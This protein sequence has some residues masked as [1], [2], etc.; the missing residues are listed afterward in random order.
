MQ[1]LMFPKTHSSRSG[2]TLIELLVVLGII[3]VVATFALPAMN[4][5]LKGSQLTQGAQMISDQINLARQT[6]LSANRSVE[7]RFYQYGDPQTPGEQATSPGTGKYRAIQLFEVQDTGSATALGKVVSMPSSIIL[8]SGAAL[9]TLLGTSLQKT[10]TSSDPQ[11]SLPR[12]G[13]SY[14]CCYMRFLPDGS[15]NLAPSSG[16]PWFLTLHG[17]NDGDGLAKPPT[18]FFTIQLDPTNGHTKTFRP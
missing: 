3:A 12:V 8:D 2:F 17:I 18:N 11:T 15:T 10:W 9:S 4:T 14:N 13:T 5:V 1:K 16:S 7:V 6:A